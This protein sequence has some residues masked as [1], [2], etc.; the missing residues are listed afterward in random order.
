MKLI[1][2]M[3]VTALAT[4]TVFGSF[5][6]SAEAAGRRSG[7]QVSGSRSDDISIEYKFSIFSTDED[8]NLFQDGDS[9]DNSGSFVNAITDFKASSSLGGSDI[10]FTT[11][12]IA[13]LCEGGDFN[14]PLVNPFTLNLETRLINAG[15]PILLPSGHPAISAF[16]ENPLIAGT[17]RIEY[18]L[19]GDQLDSVGITEIA[20]IIE[21]GP[22]GNINSLKFKDIDSLDNL[23]KRQQAVNSL[24][25]ILENE[26]LD[27]ANSIR[28][29]GPSSTGQIVS[30]DSPDDFDIN[31]EL[32]PVPEHTSVNSLLAFG[33]VGLGLGIKRKLQAKQ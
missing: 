16:D 32:V 18:I 24:E 31:A 11:F 4:A 5:V 15:D 12:C 10:A 14:L 28:V 2:W 29:S 22:E 3:T 6:E 17:N 26:I 27:I 30:R 9:K 20:L 8:G 13:N 23:S 7:N 21:E 19:F 33:I 25:Y 1:K